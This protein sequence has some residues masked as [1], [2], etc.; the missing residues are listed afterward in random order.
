[1]KQIHSYN[2]LLLMEQETF[3]LDH[4]HLHLIGNIN[5]VLENFLDHE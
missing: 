2:L 4:L 3:H 5:M 1:M